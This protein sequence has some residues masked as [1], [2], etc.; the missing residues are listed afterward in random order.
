MG[1]N[2][3]AWVEIDN[4]PALAEIAAD[5]EPPP[6]RHYDDETHLDM[7][8]LID[9]T[10]VLLIFFILTTTMALIQKRMEAPSAQDDK[11]PQV[12]K[13]TEKDV[14]QQMIH[15]KVTLE[16]GKPVILVEKEPVELDKLVAALRKFVRSS[17]KTDL[18]LEHDDKVDLDT[19]VQIIDKAKG[20]GMNKVRMLVP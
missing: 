2:D 17:S 19:V 20:A 6:P 12:V 3:G 16:G 5:M 7:T 14:E 11:G 10:L 13:I 18:L 8:A 1:P 15:V 4:H 9:V